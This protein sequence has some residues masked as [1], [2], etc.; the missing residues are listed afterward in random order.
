MTVWSFSCTPAK[1]VSLKSWRY[2]SQS[3]LLNELRNKNL[4]EDLQENF[5]LMCTN[6]K[7]CDKDRKVLAGY[8]QLYVKNAEK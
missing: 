5:N 1:D 7:L 8:F 3:K 4:Q 2:C 6:A